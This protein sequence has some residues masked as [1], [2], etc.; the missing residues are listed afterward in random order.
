MKK[1]NRLM[2]LVLAGVMTLLMLTGCCVNSDELGQKLVE[3]TLKAYNTYRAEDDQLT[4]DE[5]LCEIMDRM[6]ALVDPET[7]EI[8]GEALEEIIQGE[9][10][11]KNILS[12]PFVTLND[13]KY[14]AVPVTGKNFEY[15]LAHLAMYATYT[16]EVESIGIAYRAEGGKVYVGFLLAF[17]EDA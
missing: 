9:C 3:E 15:A 5:E 8:D 12:E 11:V 17:P 10:A 1:L 14:Y 4:N 2:A 13:G 7:N 16:S 6:L